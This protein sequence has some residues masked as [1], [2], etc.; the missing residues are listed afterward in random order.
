MSVKF[1]YTGKLG[2]GSV[3][4]KNSTKKITVEIEDDDL[5]VNELLDEFTGFLRALGYY[6][7]PSDRLEIVSDDITDLSSKEFKFDL[8]KVDEFKLDWN[9]IYTNQPNIN[10]NVS[11]TGMDGTSDP[12]Y[13]AVP[14]PHD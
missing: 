9:K 13:G 10:F 6:V 11:Q 12:A 5:T 3:W 4:D 14:P 7:K 8:P 1:E 2:G